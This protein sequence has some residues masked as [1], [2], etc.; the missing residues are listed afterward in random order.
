TLVGGSDQITTGSGDDVVIGGI[1]ADTI[2]AG[3]GNNVVLG[4]SGLVDWAAAERGGTLAGDDLNPADID[5]IWTLDATHGG[6]DDITTGNGDDIVIGGD[7]GELIDHLSVTGL[8]AVAP[9]MR[10][11]AHQGDTIHAGDGP[12][13]V[14]G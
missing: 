1:N 12:N 11:D 2:D 5:R 14:F 9:Q 13:L 3:Q 10:I 7:D 8:V 6:S 4:D